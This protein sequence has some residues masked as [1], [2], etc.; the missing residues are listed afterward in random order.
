MTQ[1]VDV[2]ALGVRRHQRIRDPRQRFLKSQ[3]GRHVVKPGKGDK[4]GNPVNY[5]GKARAIGAPELFF[6][7][8]VPEMQQITIA[9]SQRR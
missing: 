1:M 7:P 3:I 5:T 2:A 9:K 6:G 4:P 8:G